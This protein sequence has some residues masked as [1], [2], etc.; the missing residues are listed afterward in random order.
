MVNS[1]L[2]TSLEHILIQTLKNIIRAKE[3]RLALIDVAV[4]GFLLTNRPLAGTQDAQLLAPLA[5]QLLYS[6]EPPIP[7]DKE[8]K[9]STHKLVQDVIDKDFE[10][11]YQQE[12]P[13][14]APSTLHRPL[15][16]T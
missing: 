7:S 9:E 16:P 10:V 8:T 12:D 14:V 11:F 1:G 5:S 2:Y 13:N 6:Q 4:V 3:P 15:L